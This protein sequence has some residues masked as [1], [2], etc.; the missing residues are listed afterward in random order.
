[1]VTESMFIYIFYCVC[2]KC[3]FWIYV[4]T[5]MHEGHTIFSCDHMYIVVLS[6]KQGMEP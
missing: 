4:S 6:W 2:D 1:M 5:K 3:G